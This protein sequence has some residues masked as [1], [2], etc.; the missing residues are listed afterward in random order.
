MPCIAILAASNLDAEQ[1]RLVTRTQEYFVRRGAQ[2][3][4]AEKRRLSEIN[5]EL[6]ARFADFRA[7]VLADENTWTVLE[8]DADLAGLPESAIATAAGRCGRARPDRQMGDRQHAIE[9]R[10][11]PDV[12]HPP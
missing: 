11:V 3:N 10:S 8:R 2:L 12:F 9:R 7:K 5:Q 6:A 1:K 4:D